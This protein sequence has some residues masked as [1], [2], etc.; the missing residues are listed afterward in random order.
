[1][2]SRADSWR[3]RSRKCSSGSSPTASPSGLVRCA[4]R[5]GQLL[6]EDTQSGEE[7]AD[8]RSVTAKCLRDVGH[9]QGPHQA[10]RRIAQSSHHFGTAAL[11]N[12]A[13]VLTPG[14]VT[15][16]MRTIRDRPVPPRPFEQLTGARHPPRN[17]G[18][19]LAGF[20]CGLAVSDHF[21]VDLP[22]LSDTR[23][24]QVLVP[25]C[26]CLQGATFAATV[27]LVEGRHRVHRLIP[28]SLLPR[29]KKPLLARGRRPS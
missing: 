18:D 19:E 8:L 2:P 13:G 15:Y 28:N 7:N 16:V 27:S 24:I 21:A 4:I 12:P 1:M 10:D 3:A 11:A 17:T 20:L 5:Q 26:G 25:R 14:D 22:D 9:R 29:G 23:P 6:F